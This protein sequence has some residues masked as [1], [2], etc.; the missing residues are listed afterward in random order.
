MLRKIFINLLIAFILFPLVISM[1]HWSNI[2]NGIYK[3]EDAYYNSF[4]EYLRDYLHG[5]AYP[6][7]PTLFLFL[8]LFPFQLMKDYF[9]RKRRPL[10]LWIKCLIFSVLFACC[11]MFLAGG[12]MGYML[13][14]NPMRFWGPVI[15]GG[16]LYPILLY[17]TVD[18]YVERSNERKAM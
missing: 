4:G 16:I 11:Y 9:A 6:I 5:I 1:R 15:I 17:F 18:R 8:I 14:S 13:K 2:F 7:V 10:Y 3:I 12:Y